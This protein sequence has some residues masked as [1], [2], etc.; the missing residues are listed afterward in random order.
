ML[1]IIL[2][3][4]VIIFVISVFLKA[5]ENSP[6]TDKS[7]V[8]NDG[9]KAEATNQKKVNGKG[10]A[11]GNINLICAQY[12]KENEVV[13]SSTPN[14]YIET[15]ADN[16]NRNALIK[17]NIPFVLQN[18]KIYV[19]GQDAIKCKE[20]LKL[21]TNRPLSNG[22]LNFN[23]SD[24]ILAEKLMIS[25]ILGK[26]NISKE[27]CY[28]S[29]PADSID[30]EVKY[31][32]QQA[33]LSGMLSEMGYS[34]KAI[35]V[36][37]AVI[38]SELANED[39]TGITINFSD[40][41]INVCA[42]NKATVAFSFS[43]SRGEDWVINNAANIS[44]KPINYLADIYKK[45]FALTKPKDKYQEAIVVS[46]RSLINYVLTHLANKMETKDALS[47]LPE[48]LT[49][50][51]SGESSALAGFI[52]IFK[53]EAEKIKFSKKFTKINLANE[54]IDAVAYGCLIAAMAE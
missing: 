50:I 14:I 10:L 51:C 37:Y 54:P 4:F 27:I 46:Y 25:K 2:T 41:L 38:M 44:N 12:N 7:E 5:E 40:N 17:I 28:F 16:E 33:N 39:F 35:T 34:P 31:Q 48:K 11:L 42:A 45:G 22:M 3:W 18:N 29:I 6:A 8:K 9:K 20:S 23:S 19:L 13:I 21:L 15:K 1:R 47:V 26:P 24:D 30:S 53:Q 52:D 43:V 32:E 49:I 36:G